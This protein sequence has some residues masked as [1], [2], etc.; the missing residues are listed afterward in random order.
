LTNAGEVSL[1]TD[2]KKGIEERDSRICSGFH[3][4]DETVSG[5]DIGAAQIPSRLEDGGGIQTDGR[6]WQTESK[7]I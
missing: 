3:F 7:L 6:S 5:D 2:G 4:G 1:R